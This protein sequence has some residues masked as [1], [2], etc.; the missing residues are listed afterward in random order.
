MNSFDTFDSFL[1]EDG[2]KLRPD[3]AV[4]LGT[5]LAPFG[6][7]VS[8][9]ASIRHILAVPET[10]VTRPVAIGTRHRAIEEH[11][12]YWEYDREEEEE[13]NQP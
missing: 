2:L 13:P 9:Y 3:Y 12:H 8:A 10:I 4:V 1:R 11:T 7:V 5:D 6:K